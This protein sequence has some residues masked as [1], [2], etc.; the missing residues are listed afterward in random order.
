M[1]CDLDLPGLK[2]MLV[3]QEDAD[4]ENGKKWLELAAS[5]WESFLRFR[6]DELK[7]HGRM[8]IC[9]KTVHTDK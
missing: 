3:I 8:H 5:D 4:N 7:P 6:E 2:G 9:L 1:S